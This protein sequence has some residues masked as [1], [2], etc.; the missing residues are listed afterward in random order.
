VDWVILFF[1]KLYD[2]EEFKYLKTILRPG[3][4]FVDVGANVGAYTA[5]ASGLV[6][7]LGRVIGIE[8]N[9]EVF[10]L[11]DEMTRRSGLTN[12]VLFDV[13]VTDEVGEFTLWLQTAGNRGASTLKPVGR[14]FSLYE[15]STS[16]K[17][18]TL[19]S[20]VGGSIRL[21]K[22]DIE[23]LEYSVL[24]QYFLDVDFRPEYIL[25]ERLRDREDSGDVLLLLKREGYRDV[26]RHSHNHL[27]QFTE[28]RHGVPPV[29]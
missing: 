11:L 21:M 22:L 27:L 4:T 18:V 20:I 16:V 23:G 5:Y 10:A 12:V 15:R 17:C 29:E 14:D 25:V 28:K 7:P 2:Y 13:G 26:W 1:P 24:R 6:G 9:P 19:S 8:A 3:D